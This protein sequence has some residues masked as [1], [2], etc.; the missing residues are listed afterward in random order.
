MSSGSHTRASQF[1]LRIVC[2]SFFCAI[3]IQHENLLAQTQQS[4][5]APASQQQQQPTP[6]P[7]KKDSPPAAQDSA[8]AQK[9]A[10]K[11]H[12]V[13][14]NDDIS[15]GPSVPVAPG[16]RRR[17]KELNRCDRACFIAVEKQAINFGYSTAY[18]RSTRQEMEDR[19]A[20]D[21]QEFN[22]N[23]KW[24]QLMLDM[25]SAHI[26]ACTSS[27]QYTQSPEN[28]PS[29]TPTREEILAEEEAAKNYRPLPPG[30]YQATSNAVMSYRWNSKPDPLQ[31]SW[32]IYQWMEESKRDCSMI[33]PPTYGNADDPDDP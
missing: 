22:H 23:P 5:D 26:N 1:F 31:A 30:S 21:I 27:Q 3:F 16:A 28:S 13:Y 14:T 19:L 9:P 25:I 33:A 24:Q 4:P 2:V 29:H 7:T 6:E 20:N 8:P 12:R 10:A 17:L 32:M 11:S 18:P 15:T